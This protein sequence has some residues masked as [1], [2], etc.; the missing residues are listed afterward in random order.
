VPQLEFSMR[1]MREEN[2][3]SR[4]LAKSLRRKTTHAEVL[5]WMCINKLD[6]GFRFRR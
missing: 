4:P 6:T 2:W 3:R 5:V 1:G